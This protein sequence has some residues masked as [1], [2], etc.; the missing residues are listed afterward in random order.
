MLIAI[1]NEGT[2]TLATF[3][4]RKNRF[5]CPGCG[6][7]VVLKKGDLKVAHFAHLKN[8]ICSR[9]SEGETVEHLQGKLNLYNWILSKGIEAKL[10]VFLPEISQ[11]ADIL[12]TVDQTVIAVEYQ[13]SKISIDEVC[14]RTMGY[15][16]LGISVIW[17]AGS[18][19][20][21]KDKLT[22][23]QRSLIGEIT[24]GRYCFYLYESGKH[25]LK[26]YR[27]GINLHCQIENNPERL[28]KSAI[29]GEEVCGADEPF[30]H[31]ITQS[32]IKRNIS[33]L[34]LM[35]SYRNPSYFSFFQYVY[36]NR[37]ILDRLP[38]EIHYCLSNDWMIRTVSF[39]WKLRFMIWLRQLKKGV[40]VTRRMVKNRVEVMI[41]E[42]S[43]SL[44]RCPNITGDYY[45]NPFNEFMEVLIQNHF[46]IPLSSSK[47]LVNRDHSFFNCETVPEVTI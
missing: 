6:A 24:R 36:I 27:V 32:E 31:T 45:M 11:R 42:H 28:I 21:V 41:K 1:N 35:R 18:K 33:K 12:I 7:K 40:V 3:A 25:Q 20:T 8:S 10:E 39:E 34:H 38:V 26:Y 15:H 17:I 5:T 22:A 13:C 9:Y 44:Y 37:L 19:L 16:Q 43:L 46:L 2:A 29:L 30:I 4:E 47:W 23:L 14:S